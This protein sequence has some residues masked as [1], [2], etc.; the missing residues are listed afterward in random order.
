MREMI[1]ILSD[2]G[3]IILFLYSLG[4]GMIALI[5]AAILCATGYLDL[6]ICIVVA[7]VA[8]FIGDMILFLLS[9]KG[10]KDIMVYFKNYRRQLALSQILFK[11]HGAKLIIFKKYIYGLKTLIPLA[12][13]LSKFDS[14]KF[15]VYNALGAVIWGV[16]IGV[17]SYYASDFVLKVFD[18]IPSKYSSIF[19]ILF[20]VLF[21]VWITF[22]SRK[23]SKI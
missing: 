8:N 2:Y 16:S 7:V 20:I 21:F 10:K 3:Y 17:G 4:G 15:T 9:K 1:E 18:K 11:R 13:G 5:A 22:V 14:I 12:I 23:K 6:T 19:S